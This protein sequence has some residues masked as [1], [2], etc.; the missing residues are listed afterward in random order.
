MGRNPLLLCFL[1]VFVLAAPLCSEAAE[2]P[3][4]FVLDRY[5]SPRMGSE[6]LL[7]LHRM[8]WSWGDKILK[9]SWS[10][11]NS[12]PDKALGLTYRLAKSVFLDHLFDTYVLQAQHE[13]FGH[14]ARLREYGYRESQFR[15]NWPFPFG[16]G[17]A[18]TIRGPP[19]PGRMVTPHEHLAMFGGGVESTAVMADALRT[20]WLK[21][22]AIH[23]R[24]TLLY[25]LSFNDDAFYIWQTDP[26]TENG[27]TSANDILRYLNMLH[28]WE[29]VSGGQSSGPS[30]GQLSNQAFINLLNPFQY[31]ALYTY[32]FTYLWA[33]GSDLIF[34]MIR[35]G[36]LG[37]LPAFRFGL[38]PFGSE[39][40][41]EHLFVLDEVILQGSL[42]LSHPACPQ[43]FW[44]LS[45]KAFDLN[46]SS[47]WVLDASADVW[48]QPQLEVGGSSLRKR[49]G[50]LGGAFQATLFHRVRG[51]GGAPLKILLNLG[52]K[53]AG[54][55]EGE[56][57]DRGLILRVGIRL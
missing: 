13:Y 17:S 22:G 45:L 29:T 7:S 54:Y 25:L 42:K 47:R 18:V 44:G 33:G 4:T 2:V 51:P 11:E 37:Y 43:S 36:N 41:S 21:R 28:T 6:L 38:T 8:A 10:P 52:Y 35:I 27:A 14:G 5:Q 24:E 30:L 50:G 57:L 23:Y 26:G 20:T 40:L 55:V 31:Y 9:P 16:D 53:T 19:P 3:Y 48:H 12:V 56:R 1:G 34:P 39:Y 32:L 49:P 46:L 15:F